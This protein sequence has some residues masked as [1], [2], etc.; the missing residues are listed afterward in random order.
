MM[1]FS[2]LIMFFL[3]ALILPQ[4]SL[5]KVPS[6][7]STIA[8]LDKAITF[9]QVKTSS[10]S[11]TLL[12]LDQRGGL[13]TAINLSRLLKIQVEDPL[14]LITLVG[15]DRLMELASS[16]T[17]E[18]SVFDLIAPTKLSK[19]QLAVGA[20][21][22]EHGEEGGLDS[23]FLF[24]K[25][26]VPTA[27]SQS[28]PVSADQL[29]DY[30]VEIC[31]RFDRD[32]QSPE[33]FSAATVGLFLCGDFTDRATLMRKIDKYNWES[34]VG[35][36]DGKSGTGFFPIGVLTVVP[37]DWS[38]FINSIEMSLSLNGEVRQQDSAAKMQ[39]KLH[40]IIEQAFADHN[41]MN[42]VF[43]GDEIPLLKGN[44]L[45]RGQ[46][47]LTGTP[48][49]VTFRPPSTKFIVI[50]ALAWVVSGSF[51]D[52]SIADFIVEH[53]IEDQLSAGSYLQSGDTISMT[54]TYLG[55][56]NIALV[57]KD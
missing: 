14:E 48:E 44:T 8:P 53:Y 45:Y 40:E 3:W 41:D 10:G 5:A 37:R 51:F 29:L 24:P 4:S 25:Y 38:S 9:A 35:Y 34:G 12:V 2:L 28:L 52:S 42:W 54:A 16:P 39:M 49:G 31:A 6:A 19:Q 15:A 17:D 47:V 30:E 43:Q 7:H 11:D 46:S 55:E 23:V 26:S 32:I 27:G 33:D 50:N 36:T 56:I 22:A 13:V 20:N 1:K 57:A 21:Y 18:Y